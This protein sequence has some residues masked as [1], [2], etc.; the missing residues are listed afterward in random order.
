MFAPFV[1]GFAGLLAILIRATLPLIGERY[2]Q[3]YQIRHS[4]TTATS[5]TS[6]TLPLEA[7]PEAA[8]QMLQWREK[9]PAICNNCNIATMPAVPIPAHHFHKYFAK[10]A[11][12]TLQIYCNSIVFD[13]LV[14]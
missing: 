8:L 7:S 1:L 12:F 3:I 9:T 14:C 10:N 5:A 6:A 2:M 13:L 11:I 4:Y